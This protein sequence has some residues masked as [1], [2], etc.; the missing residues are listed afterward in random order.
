M[1]KILS[2]LLAVVTILFEC[3][4]PVYAAESN[5]LTVDQT[6]TEVADSTWSFESASSATV[7]SSNCREV[8]LPSDGRITLKGSVQGSDADI[9][10]YVYDQ[11]GKGVVENVSVENGTFEI[12]ANTIGGKHYIKFWWVNG[13]ATITYAVSF[14]PSQVVYDK[15]GALKFGQENVEYLHDCTYSSATSSEISDINCRKIDVTKN[16]KITW[17]AYTIG[18]GSDVRVYVYDSYGNDIITNESVE[19]GLTT[20]S[21][22]VPK[23]TYYMKLWE[24]FGSN[25]KF[26]YTLNF[27]PDQKITNNVKSKTIKYSTLKKKAQSFKINAKAKSTLTYKKISDYNNSIKISSK[28][29]VTVPKGLK[30]GT[31]VVGVQITAKETAKYNQSSKTFN[32]KIRVK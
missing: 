30:K 32:L 7:G 24:C 12:Y 11:Y 8:D 19:S 15:N 20:F 9:R 18:S 4:I 14:T 28:G 6:Y 5:T 22:S 23:G 3:N 1:K 21:A 25:A 29:K 13:S 10:V 2:I 16:G 26:T 17:N 31:Y 27:K